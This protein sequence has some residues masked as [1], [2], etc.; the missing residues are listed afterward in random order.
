MKRK[1]G[2]L[3]CNR[4]SDEALWR[5]AGNVGIFCLCATENS[6][7]WTPWVLVFLSHSFVFAFNGH[8]KVTD[9]FFEA[10]FRPCLSC[11]HQFEDLSRLTF[12]RA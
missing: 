4:I 9:L 10:Y 6:V 1:R 7:E 5:T 2:E 8:F 3:T 11:V 12:S